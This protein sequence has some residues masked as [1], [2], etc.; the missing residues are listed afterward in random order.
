[1]NPDIATTAVYYDGLIA[2]PE[3]LALEIALDAEADSPNARMLNYVSLA[4]GEKDS[5]ILRDELTGETYT[6]R[7]KLLINAAGPWIDVANDKIGISTQYIAGTKG[8]HVIV[9][10]PELRAAIGSNEFFFENKDGRIVLLFPL[11]DRVLIGTSDIKIENPDEVYCTDEEVEY[12]LE[13]VTRVFPSIKVGKEH[14]VFQF[15][16]VRPLGS[17]G[18]AKT[19]AQYSRDHHIEVL[20]GGQTKLSFPV[21]SL[22][23]G[24]WTSFR[25][26]S[27]QVADKA[28]AFLGKTRQKVTTNL[29]IGGGRGY[30]TDPSEQSRQ[31]EKMSAETGINKERAQVLYSRYGSRAEAVARYIQIESDSPL[32]LSPDYSR[33]EIMF[34][35]QHEKSMRLDDLLLRRTMLAMLGH[36]T[37]ESVQELGEI[38]GD[39]MGWDD[40]QKNAEVAYTLSLLRDRHGVRL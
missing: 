14:I 20:D 6:V 7:P 5:V 38:F 34:L 22:V 21:F 35:V 28:L 25:A 23:G 9:D 31:I 39:C 4:G 32:K 37:K 30:S 11:Y 24:K 17:S 3:R 13:L 19:T 10:H 26:F 18:A 29:P 33:R 36:L 2:N 40:K 8:S 15:T 27:E 1:L 16:G 12:F